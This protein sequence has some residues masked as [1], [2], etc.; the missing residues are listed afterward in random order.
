MPPRGWGLLTLRPDVTQSLTL[1]R[2]FRNGRA[3]I[4]STFFCLRNNAE[5]DGWLGDRL[6]R[7]AATQAKME[8]SL[9]LT[10]ESIHS[11][12]WVE[13]TSC[14]FILV[15]AHS[16]RFRNATSNWAG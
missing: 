13:T 15:V 11:G 16:F 10:P 14:D 2:E 7:S 5:L 3:L 1:G 4:R 8:R 9:E 12:P 6:A